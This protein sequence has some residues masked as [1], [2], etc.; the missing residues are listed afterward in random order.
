M[1]NK[2]LP[3]DTVIEFVTPE[4]FK[5]PKADAPLTPR[6]EWTNNA[7]GAKVA[8]VILPN[9]VF[10][11]YRADGAQSHVTVLKPNHP[12]VAGMPGHFHISQ[13]EMYN[14]PFHVPPPDEVILEEKWD[15]GE[16]FRS[17]CVWELG[18]G[19]VFYFRPGHETYGVFTQPIPLKI[20]ANAVRWLGE[21]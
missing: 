14:E 21:K 16:H 8:R 4:R 1:R 6:T 15:K 10:P 9:C 12:I 5:V 17:G 7:D 20:M 18:K 11:S 3:A 2:T 13:T 19:K